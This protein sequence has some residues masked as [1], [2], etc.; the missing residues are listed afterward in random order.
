MDSGLSLVWQKLAAYTLENFD[1]NWYKKMIQ[2]YLKRRNKIAIYLKKIGLTFDYP[3]GGLYLWAKIPKEAISS[4]AFSE[5][6]LQH[7]KVFITPGFIF[8]K[9]GERF[10]RLSL[11]NDEKLLNEALNRILK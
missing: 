6:I 10:I 9:N 5:E 1:D 8:G 3:K 7:K 2:S 11:A 4:M